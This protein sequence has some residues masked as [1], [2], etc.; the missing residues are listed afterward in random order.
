VRRFT[1][2]Q[3]KVDKVK[4]LEKC[5][6]LIAFNTL[7]TWNRRIDDKQRQ[8]G[9]LAEV[10]SGILQE[11]EEKSNELM[12]DYYQKLK[13]LIEVKQGIKEVQ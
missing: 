3:K 11:E 4:Y 5:R 12:N 7:H 10:R 9:V 2:V 8:R 6:K 13:Q 1:E